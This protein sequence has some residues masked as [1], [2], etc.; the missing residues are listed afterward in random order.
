MKYFV[1]L[2]TDKYSTNISNHIRTYKLYIFAGIY[3]LSLM[4]KQG[5]VQKT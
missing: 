4:R 2:H 3:T 1:G 5:K